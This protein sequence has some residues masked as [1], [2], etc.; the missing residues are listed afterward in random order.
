MHTTEELDLSEGAF[1]LQNLIITGREGDDDE[2][3]DNGDEGAD[4]DDDGQDDVDDDE[5]KDDQ[6]NIDWEA[7]A[8]AQEE[9]LRKERKLRRQAERE[10][11]KAKKSSTTEAKE[12]EE[13]EAQQKLQAEQQK[14]KRLAEGL[15][16]RAVDDAIQEV[17][18]KLKFIDPT[19]ALLDE[20]RAEIDVD[21]DDEDPTDI[22]IDMDS[23]R[24]AVKDLATRKKHLI[25]VEGPGAPS[26]SKFRSRGNNNTGDQA[27]Q[28]K[29]QEAYPSLR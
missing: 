2:G 23:V 7:K 11:R 12:A 24:D 15:R 29:L 17:A 14:T 25:G 13:N 26:G 6:G 21:Q 19:D 9:A 3:D 22:D 5:H 20:I 10:A 28:Q 16:K 1:W 27:E 4:G 8:K 18:R